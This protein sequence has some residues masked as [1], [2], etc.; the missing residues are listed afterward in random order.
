MNL[1]DVVS[2]VLFHL[3]H[4]L[5]QAVKGHSRFVRHGDLEAVNKKRLRSPPTHVTTPPTAVQEKAPLINYPV[6]NIKKRMK[7]T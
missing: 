6:Q 1:I 7:M 3:H 5:T 2:L 4:Q